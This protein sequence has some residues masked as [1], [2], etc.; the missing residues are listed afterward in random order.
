MLTDLIPN[1]N[2]EKN[3]NLEEWS[4]INKIVLIVLIRKLPYCNCDLNIVDISFDCLN[5]SIDYI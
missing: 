3:V 2:G 5:N 4:D 1:A